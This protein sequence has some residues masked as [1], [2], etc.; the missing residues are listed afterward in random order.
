[1]LL[2]MYLRVQMNVKPGQLKIESISESANGKTKNAF[3]VRLMIQFRVNLITQ[4]ELHLKVNFNIYICKDAQEGAPDVALKSTLLVHLSCTC[5]CNCQCTRVYKMIQHFKE[6]LKM[7]KKVT[8]R[9]HLTLHLMVHLKVH[10][11][12]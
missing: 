2:K 8:I 6:P 9:M 11:S 3:Q 12:V 4:L 1:M 5:S 10:W 7:H